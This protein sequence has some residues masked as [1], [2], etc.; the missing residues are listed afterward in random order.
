M[1]GKASR[2]CQRVSFK[3]NAVDFSEP[4]SKKIKA[5]PVV[6]GKT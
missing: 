4:V 5:V 2:Y 1:P 6:K 3:V